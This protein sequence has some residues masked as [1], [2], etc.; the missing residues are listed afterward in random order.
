MGRD[1][2]LYYSLTQTLPLLSFV[3]F[4]VAFFS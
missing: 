2:L 4:D 1:D 3:H